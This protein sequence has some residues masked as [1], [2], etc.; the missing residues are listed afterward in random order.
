MS[1][2]LIPASQL[3]RNKMMDNEEV[4]VLLTGTSSPKMLLA[5]SCVSIFNLTDVKIDNDEWISANTQSGQSQ[6]P[7]NRNFW[8]ENWKNPVLVDSL[9]NGNLFFN[10]ENDCN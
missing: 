2:I 3:K 1:S 7:Q 4:E 9:M 8:N 10:F 5:T 6:S